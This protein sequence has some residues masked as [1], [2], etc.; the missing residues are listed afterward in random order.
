MRRRRGFTLFEIMIV[1]VI[2]GL[3]LAITLPS[4]KGTIGKTRLTTSARE[5]TALMR[6]ARSVAV[7]TESRC[8]LR[9]SPEEDTFQLVAYDKNGE[10]VEVEERRARRRHA[11]EGNPLVIGADML[12]VQQLPRRVHFAVIYTAADLTEENGLPR[13][14]FYPDGSATPATVAIEDEDGK[15]IRVEVYRTTGMTRV[16]DGLPPQQPPAQRLYYGPGA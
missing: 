5:I 6:F 15:T 3:V 10:R 14:I 11:D 13:V 9:F 1:V 4:I 12:N 8:E 7:L 2:L 16:E